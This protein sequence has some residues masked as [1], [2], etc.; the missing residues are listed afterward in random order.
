MHQVFTF[1]NLLV[2]H[3]EEKKWF[4]KT[5]DPK[6]VYR[7][8][9]ALETESLRILSKINYPD[10]VATDFKQA[11]T[12]LYNE[13]EETK[14]LSAMTPLQLAEEALKQPIKLKLLHPLKVCNTDTLFY[15]C[16]NYV[17]RVSTDGET[18]SYTPLRRLPLE[19]LDALYDAINRTYIPVRFQ[20]Q[21]KK[22]HRLKTEKAIQALEPKAENFSEKFKILKEITSRAFVHRRAVYSDLGYC[23]VQTVPEVHLS[24]LVDGEQKKTELFPDIESCIDRII[25]IWH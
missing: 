24:F 6:T 18:G 1:Q 21:I 5:D 11:V 16:V 8:I 25:E 14:R 19:I 23:V 4:I 17:W 2:A 12:R 3:D 20:N 13:R 7:V 9:E 10:P 15:K 22:Y